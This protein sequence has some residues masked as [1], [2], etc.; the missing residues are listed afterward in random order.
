ML[1][2]L[3]NHFELILFTSSSKIYCDGIL[4]N[5]IE[6]EETFFDHKLFKNHLAAPRNFI[7]RGSRMMSSQKGDQSGSLIKN[8]DILLSG[9]TLGDLLIVDNRSDMYCD[10][11]FNGIPI[12]DYQGDP[13]D[14]ALYVLKDYLMRR[15]LPVEDVRQ[16]IKEDFL[17]A[18]FS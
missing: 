12:S 2:E 6:C 16:S 9:R 17:D 14:R 10:H 15:I 1:R 8:L 5:V 13:K 11:V 18:V 7:G 3:K 4:K